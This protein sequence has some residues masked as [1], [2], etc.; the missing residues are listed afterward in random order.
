[1][2][3]WSGDSWQHAPD[4]RKEHDPQ[5]WA[6][7]CFD[8]QGTIQNLTQ[9][10]RW[11]LLKTDDPNFGTSTSTSASVR[12]FTYAYR[13][14]LHPTFA[15]RM[16]QPPL[17]HQMPE[18]PVWGAGRSPGSSMKAFNT[19]KAAI[20]LE[21]Q[22]TI[23]GSM[24]WGSEDTI[25]AENFHKLAKLLNDK[26]FTIGRVNG[27]H[28]DEAAHM[29]NMSA[30]NCSAGMAA[31]EAIL[32]PR[33][34]GTSSTE[35][36]GRWNNNPLDG[37]LAL[38][39]LEPPT[40]ETGRHAQRSAWSEYFE[41]EFDYVGR[42]VTQLSTSTDE[43]H[44]VAET[45]FVTLVGTESSQVYG[46]DQIEYAVNRGAAKQH[47]IA[48]GA[49]VSVSNGFG[50]KVP[51]PGWPPVNQTQ[52]DRDP[53]RKQ[54]P[55]CGTSLSLMSRLLV[56]EILYGATTATIEDFQFCGHF[57]KPHCDAEAEDGLGV[58][59]SIGRLQKRLYTFFREL[60]RNGSD[61]S[62]PLGGATHVA[63]F[64]V[65]HDADVGWQYPC[66][67]A[68]NT[69]EHGAQ[70]FVLTPFRNMR[71]SPWRKADFFLDGVLDTMYPGYAVGRYGRDERGYLSP[72]PHGDTLD[73]LLDDV[74]EEVL[75]RYD[76]VVV[77]GTMHRTP[78]T[79]LRRLS[80]LIA[81]GGNVIITADALAA[82][83]APLLG[84]EAAV[85]AACVQFS[86]RTTVIV[87]TKSYLETQPF[88][89]CPLYDR[90]GEHTTEMVAHEASTEQVFALRARAASGEGWLLVLAAGNSS[91]AQRS[92]GKV[93]Y[94]KYQCTAEQ[95][96]SNPTPRTDVPRPFPLLASTRVVL[97]AALD[98][99]TLFR[100]ESTGT[101]PSLTWSAS[102][103]DTNATGFLL[104]ISNPTYDPKPFQIQAGG[105][106]PTGT[107]LSV[108]EIAMDD[109]ERR[110][111]GFA[112]A[113]V[114]AHD[115]SSASEIAG[116]GI[117]VFRVGVSSGAVVVLPP[118]DERTVT[119][120]RNTWLRLNDGNPI[121][122]VSDAILQ[123]PSLLQDVSG[124]VLPWRYVFSTDDAAL[125]RDAKTAANRKV[126][127]AVDAT[128]AIVPFPH[129]RLS[130]ESKSELSRSIAGLST[131]IRKCRLL[132]AKTL[133][134]SLHKIPEFSRQSPA[135]LES[136]QQHTL[137]VLATLAENA[138]VTLHI[139]DAHK[140]L[141]PSISRLASFVEGVG[142]AFVRVAPSTAMML[143]DLRP[144]MQQQ[145]HSLLARRNAS[146]LLLSADISDATG[147]VYTSNGAIATLGDTWDESTPRLAKAKAIAIVRAVV[148]NA[149][150]AGATVVLD[151]A[152]S[153]RDEELADVDALRKLDLR[154]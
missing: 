67:N 80:R 130:N 94:T 119:Q 81:S 92:S 58:P 153:D 53:T 97:R 116:G 60:T 27:F 32:G 45:G 99:R 63:T 102:V 98:D 143:E 121:V 37:Q 56:H 75:R 118:A 68:N 51:L 132:T 109:A 134:L 84:I 85:G 71:N 59:T 82:L 88:S 3:M 140:N 13:P 90:G 19:T 110:D 124:L 49:G 15:R 111:V 114:T 26:N 100:V 126:E 83:G 139:R 86:A 14:E 1:M 106:L 135:E 145:Y 2:M 28:P 9:N 95:L 120:G 136:G 125:A 93:D 103:L 149:R 147:T 4:G 127:L 62:A 78:M 6:E 41:S 18:I 70:G 154:S 38:A 23:G 21:H 10:K 54:G 105:G 112:P 87:G 47:G 17:A 146:I 113:G 150:E 138:G 12:V 77:T 115:A 129:W 48:L 144:A 29:L 107:K 74:A 131:L 76:T 151:A 22:A 101:K 72:T 117:R 39:S 31:A 65:I 73:F 16:S 152:F 8:A 20:A 40:G 128:E 104:A 66:S 122:S 108:T 30:G 96:G 91:T 7:L 35:E 24:W 42:K 52:C 69:W 11:S 33:F 123:R 61:P 141:T 64:A 5:W 34:L 55:S 57:C 148:A 133:I 142:S 25:C 137:R 44:L 89:L 43:T 79:I 36:G 50:G 46:N